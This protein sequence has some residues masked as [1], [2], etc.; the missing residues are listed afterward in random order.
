M[1][2]LSGLTFFLVAALVNLN[3]VPVGAAFG[4]TVAFIPSSAVDDPA[5]VHLKTTLGTLSFLT[6]A[7]ALFAGKAR[8]LRM[9][10]IIAPAVK[11]A[12]E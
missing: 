4:L 12:P 8:Q 7:V 1:L 9:R 11:V 6:P 5:G 10:K 2:G 3:S